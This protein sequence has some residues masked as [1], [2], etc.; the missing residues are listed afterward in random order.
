MKL[1]GIE[2]IPGF[3]NGIGAALGNKPYMPHMSGDN[4]ISPSED[5]MPM[6][7]E[8][9]TPVAVTRGQNRIMI[10]AGRFADAATAKANPTRKVTFM[11]LNIIPKAMPMAPTPR[12][13]VFPNRILVES[14]RPRLR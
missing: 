8:A 1:S 12:A 9:M 2:T 4:A 11:P 5:T 7:M 14:E 13:A 3:E 6:I 10:M